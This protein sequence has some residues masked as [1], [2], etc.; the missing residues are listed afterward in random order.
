VADLGTTI[1]GLQ[2]RVAVKV[3]QSGVKE[4]REVVLLPIGCDSFHDL[5]EV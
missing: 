3:I 4:R 2:V 5:V 1:A